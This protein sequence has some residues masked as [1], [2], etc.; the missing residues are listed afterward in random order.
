MNHETESLNAMNVATVFE[1]K[2][3]LFIASAKNSQ[4]R[5]G[6]GGG[7][8]RHSAFMGNCVTISHTIL[9]LFTQWMSSP[10]R[11]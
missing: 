5:G 2:I 4:R 8:Y 7:A 6:G 1:E 11:E 3:V 10:S 9:A